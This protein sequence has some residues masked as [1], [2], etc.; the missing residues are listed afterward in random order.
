MTDV[1][2]V[3]VDNSRP[4]L[5][6]G[7]EGLLR[8]DFGF[9]AAAASLLGC[10]LSHWNGAVD[11]AKLGAQFVILKL[12]G[13]DSGRYT[14]RMYST[15]A[16][17]V[18]AAKKH[19]GHYWFNGAGDPVADARYFVANLSHY[20]DEDL[21]VLDIESEIPG[22]PWTPSHALAWFKEVRALKPKARLVA[23]MSSSVT[24]AFDWSEVVKFGVELWVA[25]Y[26][27]NTGS[28]PSGTPVVGHWKNWIIWQYTSV[29]RIAGV[30]GAV[31]LNFAHPSLFAP[32]PAPTP[33]P[34]PVPK[35]VP[36]VPTK[37]EGTAIQEW[38]KHG[39]YTGPIDGDPQKYTWTAC[40]VLLKKD[41]GYTGIEDGVPGTLTYEAFE[42]LA[43]AKGGYTG[44]V[45]NG[46]PDAALWAAV[47]KAVT[48]APAHVPAPVP[49][50]APAPAPKPIPAPTPTPAPVPAP[51]PPKDDAMQTIYSRTFAPNQPVKP[52]EWTTVELDGKGVF[53]FIIANEDGNYDINASFQFAGIPVGDSAQARLAIVDANGKVLHQTPVVEFAGT[54]GS[55]FAALGR[56]VALKKGERLR[57]QVA[58]FTPGVVLARGDVQWHS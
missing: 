38:A 49:A 29:G 46:V 1:A 56:F 3:D 4:R 28:K 8:P 34:K 50:P 23:Y 43:K 18:R 24:T 14:D 57:V 25:N 26:G 53:S 48:P 30:P 19:L 20:Q 58:A 33:V 37:A 13:S 36:A 31:D 27:A 21:L 35:P 54:P 17:E 5:S 52:A 12:G 9:A 39:G 51:V 11:I 32:L 47:A 15:W 42:R 55:T 40:Q 22:T 6:G 2:E 7:G 10:D 41:W 45:T 16:P 44:S